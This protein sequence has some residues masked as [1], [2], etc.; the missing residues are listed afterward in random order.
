MT[1]RTGI[2]VIY[3]GVQFDEGFRADTLVDRQLIDEIKGVANIVV[4]HDVPVLT[5]LRMSGLHFGLLLFDVRARLRKD[6][7]Q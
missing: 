6:G 4:A 5:Y 1:R 2:P 7:L 3:N